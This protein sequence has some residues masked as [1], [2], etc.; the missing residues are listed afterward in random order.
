MGAGHEPLG[1]TKEVT[2][3]RPGKFQVK[4]FEAGLESGIIEMTIPQK[5]NSCMQKYRLTASGIRLKDSL[6]YI[7]EG[8]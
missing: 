5:P 3:V 6:G 4:L 8:E 7:K 1:N 2:I